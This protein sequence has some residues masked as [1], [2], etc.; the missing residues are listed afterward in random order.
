MQNNHAET[1]CAQRQPD[2][3]STVETVKT[4]TAVFLLGLAFV[5][6]LAP[7]F[8]VGVLIVGALGA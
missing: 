3:K 6:I 7:L 1:R 8:I 2:Q 4:K 5:T